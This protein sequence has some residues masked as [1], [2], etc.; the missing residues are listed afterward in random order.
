[1]GICFWH[2]AFENDFEWASAVFAKRPAAMLDY[3][4][5]EMSFDRVSWFLVSKSEESSAASAD[6]HRTLPQV[7]L[8]NPKQSLLIKGT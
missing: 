8:I 6:Q 1:M 2:L 7:L 5:K 4:E 3:S